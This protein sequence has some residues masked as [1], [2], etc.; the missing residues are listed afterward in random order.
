MKI[1]L[2]TNA[3]LWL[4]ADDERLSLPTRQK[5]ERATEIL[6]SEASLWEIAIKVSIKK[7]APIPE[8]YTT[9]EDLG[10]K[11]L[12]FEN[13]HLRLLE[14]LP[15]LHRD[16]FDRMLVAQA[17]AENVQIVSSYMF[18]GKYGIRVISA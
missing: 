11:R 8:L 13:E 15:L 2:D 14:T 6:V 12:H 7:L 3:L 4:L 10:F 1:L 5:L 9:L 17:L 16:L 18:L